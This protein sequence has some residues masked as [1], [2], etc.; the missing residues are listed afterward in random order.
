ML[1]QTWGALFSVFTP[2]NT[3]WEILKVQVVSPVEQVD[4]NK[5]EGKRYTGVVVYVMW[6]LHMTA[7]HRAEN[8]SYEG[9]VSDAAVKRVLQGLWGPRSWVRWGLGHEIRLSARGWCGSRGWGV[10]TALCSAGITSNGGD[11]AVDLLFTV[12]HV[13][14]QRKRDWKRDN[15]MTRIM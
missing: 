6:I 10:F 3:L 5:G 11:H 13:L 7:V 1:S 2:T 14:K 12:V 8:F 9:E 4:Y 15:T